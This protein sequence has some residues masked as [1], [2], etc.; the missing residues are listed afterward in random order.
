MKRFLLGGLLFLLVL[1]AGCDTS[2]T[3]TP[4]GYN[5]ALTGGQRPSLSAGHIDRIL[6]GSPAAGTGGTIYQLGVSYKIDPVF[7]LGFFWEESRFATD[8]N[9]LVAKLDLNPGSI[10]C[11][12]PSSPDRKPRYTCPTKFRK[13]ATWADGEQDWFELIAYGYVYGDHGQFVSPQCPCTDVQSVVNVYAP[14]TENNVKAYV[15][16][17]EAKVDAWRSEGYN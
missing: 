10:E 14:S 5:L 9:G 4:T 11:T 3:T 13:Y 16:T 1:L 8:P 7:F 6:A 2:S 17:V 12:G 15:S